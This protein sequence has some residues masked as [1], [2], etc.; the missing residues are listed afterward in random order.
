MSDASLSKTEFWM[1]V[2]A[3]SFALWAL[4]IPIGVSLLRE[5]F[6]ESTASLVELN[7]STLAAKLDATTRFTALE[8]RQITVLARLESIELEMR[9]I[10][11]QE[12]PAPAGP[13]RQK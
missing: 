11:R 9:Y 8:V 3:A 12:P 4:M 7:R 5:S 10:R 13:A 2:A 1:R 6:K